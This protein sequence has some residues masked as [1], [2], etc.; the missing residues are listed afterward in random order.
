[1]KPTRNQLLLAAAAVLAAGLA[2]VVFRSDPL[3]VDVAPVTVGPLRV[4]VDEEG[5]TRVRQRYVVAAPTTGRVLRIELDEGDPVT[6]G[7]L[8]ATIEAV[9]LD[10]RDRAAAQA[11]LEAAESNKSA[12]DA[13][14]AQTRA[15][16]QQARRS[17]DRAKRLHDA[18]TV[19]EEAFEQSELDLTRAEQDYEAAR[20]AA[21]AAVHEVEAAR[22]ALIAAYGSAPR[23]GDAEA[24]GER[25]CV[26]VRAPVAGRVLRVHEESERIVTAGTPLV[27]LGNP[28]ALEMVVDVLSTDAVRIQ[29]GAEVE[30]HEWG[31]ETPLRARVRRIEPSAF[32]KVS[33]LGVEE[34]RV[35]VIADLLDEAPRLGDGY[36]VE[37]RIVVWQGDGVLQVPASAIFRTGQAWGVFVVEDGLARRRPVALG[38]RGG[39][40]AEIREG[41]DEGDTVILHPSDLL[42]DGARVVPFGS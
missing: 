23:A 12:A 17:R 32:T 8:L 27:S 42:R 22:A 33:A 39:E 29:T 1:M 7:E 35:N 28:Q 41:L 31:G 6:E 18:G 4:T 20:F 2:W 10:P 25:P 14:V 16:F 37:A 15:A 21:E 36:R 40:A 30:V 34:Q 24:C 38:Q 19:S 9:P 11:R 5:E 13:R 3:R 26:E